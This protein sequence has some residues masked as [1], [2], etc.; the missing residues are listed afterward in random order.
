M[1]TS[2][3]EIF[4]R[5]CADLVFDKRLLTKVQKFQQGFVNKNEDHIAFFGGNLMGVQAVR[6]R[7]EDRNDWFDDV[8]VA[9]DASLEEEIHRL[10]AID[11]TRHVSSDVMNLSCLWVIHRFMT[12]AH[13]S[14]SEREAGAVYTLLILQYKFI[15]SILAHW[16]PRTADPVIAQTT[17]TALSKKFGLKVYGSWGALLE[18]RAK[19]TLMTGRI[20]YQTA[21]KFNNDEDIVY[22]V[23]DIQGRIKDILKNVRD[24]FTI[25]QNDK[26]GQ[27]RTS[28]STITLDGE[29]KVRDKKGMVSTYLRYLNTTI[30]DR[31]TFIIPELVAIVTNAMPAMSDRQLTEALQYLTS[32]ASVKADPRVLK[33]CELVMVHAFDYLSSNRNV[34][35]ST[36]DIPGLLSKMKA[37][38]TASRSNDPMVLEM[39]GL[40][41]A[42]VQQAVKTKNQA[43]VAAIRTGVLLY[44]LLRTFT[45]KHFTK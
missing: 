6:F 33:V 3:K 28:S 16:F 14:Q 11:P 31:N 22:M 39:R 29:I 32:N 35:S 45:M 36:N 27:I 13:L 23:N 24:V 12:S 2:L 9:D 7:R 37:L 21:I 40:T 30:Q 20:H 8:L 42:M 15:T 10:P 38:Y 5:Q 4:D 41:E 25:V 19:E 34:L 17:Y 44:L 26:R 1:A 18:V 43:L